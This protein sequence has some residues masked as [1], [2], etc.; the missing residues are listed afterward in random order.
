MRRRARMSYDSLLIKVLELFGMVW[1]SYV[2]IVIR[3]DL[4]GRDEER[5]LMRGDNFT[6]VR[7]VSNCK[8]VEDDCLL[9]TSPSPRDA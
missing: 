8:G 4:P 1:T 5:V 9:Y 7:W 3:K 6:A 2:M